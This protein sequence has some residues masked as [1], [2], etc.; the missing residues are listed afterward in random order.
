M[1]FVNCT[2]AGPKHQS[3][4]AKGAINTSVIMALQE[5]TLAI[6][7]GNVALAKLCVSGVLVLVRSGGVTLSGFMQVSRQR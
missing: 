2:A 7:S 5:I 1:A 6:R 3:A 4:L